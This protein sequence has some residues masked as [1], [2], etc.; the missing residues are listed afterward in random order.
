MWITKKT[1]KYRENIAFLNYLQIFLNHTYK[2]VVIK[3]KLYHTKYL[4]RAL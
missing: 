3:K 2:P 1:K 4:K